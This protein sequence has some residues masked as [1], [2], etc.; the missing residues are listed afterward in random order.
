MKNILINESEK[1]RILS[2]H[3]TAISKENNLINEVTLQDIQ[4]TLKSKGY[5]VTA[6]NKLGPKTL[7][8]I[9]T[10]ISQLP[11][12]P[13]QQQ[14]AQSGG[15]QQGAQSGN[16]QQGGQSKNMSGKKLQLRNDYR[17]LDPNKSFITDLVI[18]PTNCQEG[19]KFLLEGKMTAGAQ[20]GRQ[21]FLYLEKEPITNDFVT[22]W[23]DFSQWVTKAE[24]PCDTKR[25]S[26][27]VWAVKL[28]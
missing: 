8:A 1:K 19:P 16:Q 15:K 9:S 26:N 24:N 27:S 7:E 21:V 14:G 25:F 18:T 20:K 13:T 2:L 3:K 23:G 10:A 17:E 6:D 4:N 28:V 5:N 11:N 12:N 22:V